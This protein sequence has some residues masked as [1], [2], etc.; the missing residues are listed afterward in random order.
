MIVKTDVYID[1]VLLPR[2]AEGGIMVTVNKLYASNSGRSPTTGDFIG[3]VVALKHDINLS[4]GL[5]NEDDFNLISA[6]ADSAVVEHSVRMM[7]DGMEYTTKSCY[8]ADLPRTIRKQRKDGKLLYENISLH[9][10]EV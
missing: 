3:D 4:W 1:D 9:I 7:F 2:C 6:P 5:L 10:V 8:I